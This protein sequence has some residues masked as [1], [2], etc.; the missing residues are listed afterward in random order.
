MRVQTALRSMLAK[1]LLNRW[2]IVVFNALIALPL[3][4]A[5]VEVASLLWGTGFRTHA[6]I[7]EAG[8]LIEGMGVIL[9]GWGVVLEERHGVSHLLGGLPSED[10][11]HEAAIDALCHHGG[12]ALLVLGLVA[13]ILVQCVEVPDHIIN[14]DRIER[15]VLTGGAVFLAFSLATLVR[16]SAGLATFRGPAPA[17]AGA[18]L[19][20][21]HPR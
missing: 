6:T 21:A 15:V 19:P 9:I 8:H 20:E 5:L 18:S 2:S 1:L 16:L 3:T 4:L 12:L 13:E 11:E 17:S 10:P 14:T 7:H